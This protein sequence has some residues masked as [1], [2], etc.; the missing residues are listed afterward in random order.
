MPPVDGSFCL[1][2][3]LSLDDKNKSDITYFHTNSIS[4]CTIKNEDYHTL[5]T[6]SIPENI[7]ISTSLIVLYKKVFKS[8]EYLQKILSS[9][10]M[11]FSDVVRQWAYMVNILGKEEY[12]NGEKQYYQVFN[13][14]RSHF[15]KDEPFQNGLMSATA[16]GCFAGNFS[17]EIIALRL[18]NEIT[19]IAPINNPNQKEA[20]KYGVK[21]LI[22]TPLVLTK[23]LTTPKFSRAKLV[24]GVH[25]QI[26]FISGT[27]AVIGEESVSVGSTLGQLEVTINNIELLL[28]GSSIYN[29][30][31]L[32]NSSIILLRIYLKDLS[33]Y[34][35]IK[36]ICE[37]RFINA[38]IVIVKSVVCRESLNIEIE[39]IAI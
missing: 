39:G 9:N 28:N 7:E 4:Y 24:Y 15:Y 25:G 2:E 30:K 13:D 19:R 12:E 18:H 5:V 11:S 6:S 21:K 26:L 31:K 27:S 17:I 8:F 1:F 10:G 3:I 22:G 32:D 35:E 16:V 23:K 38:R 37:K 36:D 14:I 33:N 29:C 34:I 20:F